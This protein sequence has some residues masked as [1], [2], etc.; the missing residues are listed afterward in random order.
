MPLEAAHAQS[1]Q[2]QLRDV[3]ILTT[4]ISITVVMAIVVIAGLQLA[5]SLHVLPLA[6]GLLSLISGEIESRYAI[7]FMKN[8]GFLK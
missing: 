2:R 3:R 6:C 4:L 7:K 5:K 8:T 1:L